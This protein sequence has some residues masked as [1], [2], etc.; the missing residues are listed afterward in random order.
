MPIP[1]KETEGVLVAVT[2][3]SPVVGPSVQ[4]VMLAMSNL[5]FVKKYL[6]RINKGGFIAQH[7]KIWT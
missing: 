4:A 5:A 3:H 7:V 6:G 1:T 2:C